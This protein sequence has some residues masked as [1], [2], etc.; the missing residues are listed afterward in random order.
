LEYNGDKEIS[1]L[2][3]ETFERLNM[4]M[5][6]FEASWQWNH[7][8]RTSLGRANFT[9]KL[10]E[11]SSFLWP[12][13]PALSRRTAVIHEVCHLVDREQGSQGGH[14]ES[15]KALMI[16]CGE[17]PSQVHYFSQGMQPKK[18]VFC[19]CDQGV[20]IGPV[21][22]RRMVDQTAAYKCTICGSH[23]RLKK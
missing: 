20:W 15:W 9:Q 14:P 7:A 16:Q 22:Y 21:R 17:E 4:T 18:E 6:S 23:T 13:A 12:F 11:F 2:F 19:D 3:H 10:I 8:F 5:L 1:H